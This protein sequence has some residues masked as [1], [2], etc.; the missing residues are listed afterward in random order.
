MADML[1]R[2]KIAILAQ[3]LGTEPTAL[4][5]LERL[6]AHNLEALLERISNE[7]FDSLAPTFAR[8]SK[9]APLV[10][11]ALV[12]IVAQ[13]AIPAEVGGRAGGSV[14]MD[15]PDR[16]SGI[17]AG[18]T[19]AYMA[20]AAPFIDPR[21]IPVFAPRIPAELLIP[22]AVELL[23]RRDYLTASRFVEHATEQLVREFERGIDDDEGLIRTAALVSSTDRLNDIVGV[24][25]VERRTRIITTAASAEPE[26]V[27]AA[28]SALAR[29]DTELAAPLSN[30]L[31]DGLDTDGIARILAIA[32]DASALPELLDITD[33]LT[34]RTLTRLAQSP[35][36][37]DDS[38][39]RT[40]EQAATTDRHRRAWQRIAHTASDPAN[41]ATA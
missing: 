18:L 41:P 30:T 29:L 37:A 4:A 35:Y 13:K 12:I 6:G 5:G 14:G 32:T 38:A 23:R 36:F 34:E 17:I 3:T 7:L 39:L 33:Q 19:P 22:T 16:A 21:V 26:T 20:D 11:N 2:A 24:L 1:T 10:P 40:M 31:F 15:H 27:L 28:L 25:P 9:L 8:V